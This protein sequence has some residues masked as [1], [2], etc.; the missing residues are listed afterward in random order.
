MTQAQTTPSPGKSDQEVKDEGYR[1]QADGKSMQDN[2][3]PSSDPKHWLWRAGYLE[4]FKDS[5]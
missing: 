3:Y 2:Y 5:N 1:A 4:A